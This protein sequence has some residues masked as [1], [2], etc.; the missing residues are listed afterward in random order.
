MFISMLLLSLTLS[1][2]ALGIGIAYTIRGVSISR[3][4]KFIIGIV[5]VIIMRISAFIGVYLKYLFPGKLTEY[6]GAAILIIMGILF[7]LKSFHITEEIPYDLDHS[8]S[9]EGKEALLLGM[10][11]SADSIS[12]GIAIATLGVSGTLISLMVGILQYSF[13]DLGSIFVKRSKSIKRLSNRYCGLFSGIIF[14][15]IA[16]ARLIFG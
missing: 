10:A 4:S 16:I 14:I 7:I 12:A 13:L 6:I 1:I 11:L 5:S 8:S 3:T 2:D 9:I 15:G